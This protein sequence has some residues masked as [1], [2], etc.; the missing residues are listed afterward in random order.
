MLGSR[1]YVREHLADAEAGL[2]KPGH[3]KHTAYYNLD[4]GTGRIRG[5]WL[6]GNYAAESI[7]RQWFQPL[8]DLGV[9][10]IA[11]RSVRGSDYASFDD[12]GVPG[13]QFMQDRLE[14]NSRTHHSNMDF[15]DRLQRD[16][17]VQMAVVMATVAYNTAVRA[18]PLPRKPLPFKVATATPTA[19]AQGAVNPAVPNFEPVQPETFSASGGQPNAWADFDNDGDLDLFVGF[20][21]GVNNKLYRNDAGKF[22]DVATELG[23]ADAPDTRAAAWGDFDGDGWIDLFVGFSRRSNTPNKLY[24]NLGAGKGFADVA[25]AAGVT[26]VGETRQPV[27]VDFDNDGDND[28]FVAFRDAPNALLRNDGGHFTDVAA[29]LG[30]ADDRKTV[31]SVWFDY[32][33]DGDLD[34]YTANQD[35]TLNGLFRNDVTKFTDVAATLGVDAAGMPRAGSNGPSVMDFDNDG[36]LDLF[37]ADYGPNMLFRHDGA[38]FTEVAAAMGVAGGEKA[39]PSNWGDYDN[40]G[41]PDLYVSSYV[42]KVTDG[43][44]YLYHNDGDRFSQVMPDL[45]RQHPASHGI[46]WADFDADGDL[47]L[48]LADNNAPGRHYLYRNLLPAA[49]ARRSIQVHVVD[50]LGHHTKAGSEVRVFAAGTRK[51][52]GTRLVDTGSGYCS[53]SVLPV[54]I[55]L[56]TLAKVDVEVVAMT[57]GGRR[58][59]KVAGVDPASLKNKPLVVKVPANAVRSTK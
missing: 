38:K 30:V 55:G 53:Q 9:S 44:D 34:L 37:V 58:V 18:E 15:Y 46:L 59:I 2:V 31:G 24:R 39:T 54:H 29:T 10:T 20:R 14:Y 33:E 50:A 1:A 21:G 41:R 22:T 35:G 25:T 45:I 7:F 11:P 3:A 6:Q 16:D 36:D 5:L 49:V 57:P 26:V 27:F 51:V 13:F 8:R 48:A 32:D 23:V 4:N 47:D 42:D 17:L 56:A 52:L 40:D 12:V 43:K 28:L 19:S